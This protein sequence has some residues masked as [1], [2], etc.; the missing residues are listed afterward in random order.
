MNAK[1]AAIKILENAKKALKE[2][3]ESLE[4]ADGKNTAQLNEFKGIPQPPAPKAPAKAIAPTPKIPQPK[5]PKM[6]KSSEEMNKARVD[7]GKSPREKMLGRIQRE[8]DLADSARANVRE[9]L[10]LAD[11]TKQLKQHRSQREFYDYEGEAKS[12]YVPSAEIAGKAL[13]NEAKGRQRHNVMRQ[14]KMPKPNLPKSERP[15]SSFLKKREGKV[16]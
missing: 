15:L 14:Q 13:L 5:M 8:K 10:D 2:K 6:G 11:K 16:K 9:V 1:L 4:K 12:K 3:I 7:E